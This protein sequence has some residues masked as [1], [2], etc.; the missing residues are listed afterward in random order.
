[1]D[2]LLRKENELEFRVTDTFCSKMLRSIF[3]NTL[4]KAETAWDDYDEAFHCCHLIEAVKKKP[5]ITMEFHYIACD[6]R[7]VGIGLV[8][9]GAIDNNLFF[10]AEFNPPEAVDK[11][12][13][14]NY[15]HISPEGRGNGE[16]WLRDIILPRYSKKSYEAFYV[17]SSHPKVFHLYERLGLE[18]GQ[19][20]SESDN[21][22]YLRQGKIFK[23]PLEFKIK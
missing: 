5:N 11:I 13:I 21:G 3:M 6:Q 20:R 7:F 14:F 18:V 17:K 22:L 19:Y 9:Y 23:I 12:L 2:Y 1:M 4:Y 15:F 8:S 16:H 10:P